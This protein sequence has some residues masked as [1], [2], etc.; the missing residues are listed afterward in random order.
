MNFHWATKEWKGSERNWN[1][2]KYYS[3]SLVTQITFKNKN[4]KTSS[5]HEQRKRT[6]TS[7][8]SF[9]NSTPEPREERFATSVHTAS[10]ST[11]KTVCTAISMLQMNGKENVNNKNL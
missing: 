3:L 10:S 2:R 7:P 1:R 11:L 9:K 6:K 8:K 4:W 5:A